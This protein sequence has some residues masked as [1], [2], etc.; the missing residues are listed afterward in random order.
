MAIFIKQANYGTPPVVTSGLILYLDA[1]NQQSYTTGSTVWNDMSGRGFNATMSGS[2]P[3]SGSQKPPYFSYSGGTP[4]FSGSNNL[5]SSI[6]TEVTIMSVA[7]ITN[8]AQRSVV[9]NKYQASGIS[10]Y[11]LEIG[12]IAGLWTN[13]M[14]FFAA[15][16]NFASVSCDYRG[17]T[18]LSANTPY[19]FTATFSKV[20]NTVAMY[21]NT[22]EMSASNAGGLI[23][24]IAADWPGGTTNYSVG[25]YLPA[26]AGIPSY[27]NQY[28]VLLYNRAL[29]LKEI[30]QNYNAFKTRFGL[31]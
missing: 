20:T 13:T 2:V 3:Y 4:Y 5:S 21:Y 27:M 8:L 16:S 26:V 15:G 1:G 24:N 6:T 23:S 14:R 25:S 11:I 28:N 7:S 19:L 29:S 17:R 18:A 12:T 30:A 10:G 22:T 31:A 9:F